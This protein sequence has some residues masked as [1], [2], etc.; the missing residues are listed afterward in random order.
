M[1]SMHIMDLGVDNNHFGQQDTL[2]KAS[3]ITARTRLTRP[4]KEKP[5]DSRCFPLP[6]FS[7]L[8]HSR[9]AIMIS[10]NTS[11]F[12]L[13]LAAACNPVTSYKNSVVLGD[14]ENYA[15]LA[16]TGIS[17]V[18][19]SIIKGD[20]AVSPIAGEAMTGFGLARDW[21]GQFSTATQVIGKA[22][23]SN[24]FEP[25]PKNLTTAVSNMEAA[26]TDAA[27][28]PNTN[29]AKINFGEG[30]LGG[31]YGGEFARLTP[32]VYTF[33]TAVTLTGDI[34]FEGS[35][36]NEGEGDTDVFIIQTTG[37]LIQAAQYNVVLS[38]GA[39]AKNIFWQVAGHVVV[40]AGAHMEGI[41]LV[42]TDVLFETLSSLNGR[43][44]AQTACNLL[45]ATITQPTTIESSVTEST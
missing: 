28:R 33:D 41:L 29:A 35:G 1:D 23:A 2:H 10:F 6:N 37:N 16:K 31:A 38:G 9:L 17:T 27:G 43:V 34:Y 3:E 12:V 39:L 19:N 36:L 24:Y 30:F 20:I 14:A 40:G 32:G 4:R 18:P 22:F 15:I 11:L 8:L 25:T 7:Q 21:S 44:L 45:M 26:Y 5:Q 42:K 13:V